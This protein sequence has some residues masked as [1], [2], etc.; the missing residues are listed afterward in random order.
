M[1]R[2][3]N[4]L[5][6]LG[7]SGRR[8][9]A[10]EQSGRLPVWALGVGVVIFALLGLLR[11]TPYVRNLENQG[12]DRIM[13]FSQYFS[14]VPTIQPAMALVE[15]DQ[16]TYTA[17]NEPTRLP[18][19][20][21]ATLIESLA[22]YKPKT[23]V[24]DV[25]LAAAYQN[26]PKAAQLYAYLGTDALLRTLR[27]YGAAQT[28]P[29]LVLMRTF[30]YKEGQNCPRYSRLLDDRMVARN[31]H[32]ALAAPVFLQTDGV[33][34][35]WQ[36]WSRSANPSNCGVTAQG[37]L[38]ASTL[39]PSVQLL[40]G[41]LAKD[42]PAA[43]LTERLQRCEQGRDCAIP[44]GRNR[45][46]LRSGGDI[47]L[48]RVVYSWGWGAKT[49]DH[50]VLRY[51]A[52]DLQN[53]AQYQSW[54]PLEALQNRIVLI[55]STY[56]PNEDWHS[57]PLGGMPGV[58][59]LV[60]AY[61][62]LAASGQLRPLGWGWR[63]LLGAALLL[64]YFLLR[65]WLRLGWA[66]SLMTYVLLFVTVYWGSLR[67]QQ[68]LWLDVVLVLIAIGSMERLLVWVNQRKVRTKRGA[69]CG[70]ES[71]FWRGPLYQP[72]HKAALSRFMS[73]PARPSAGCRKK[74]W[75]GKCWPVKPWWPATVIALKPS[76][77]PASPMALPPRAPN[78]GISEPANALP[79]SCAALARLKA[80]FR[81]WAGGFWRS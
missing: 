72:W 39:L 71:S 11:T 26:D 44:I 48:Q 62:S 8:E 3:S 58:W 54:P 31:P 29:T 57:T 68:T 43:A 75:C 78:A 2:L 63:L 28:S 60:N 33:L 80:W 25:D 56:R 6:Q 74:G 67:S 61:Q 32:I 24:L 81:G 65:Q 5:R 53:P 49:P 4:F 34:R 79:Y 77:P 42:L 19:D 46:D 18:H 21:L 41:W 16:P 13:Q 55:G 1:S 10:A 7:S 14:A 35:Y 70:W 51:S 52:I 38:S 73:P 76:S 40:L 30:Q 9:F 47:G 20:R 22:R 45:L 36:L 37:V 64:L 12:L 66:R 27:G 69:A 17:W 59:V 15:I 50:P 23:I